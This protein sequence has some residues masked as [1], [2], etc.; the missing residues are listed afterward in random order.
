MLPQDDSHLRSMV[1]ARLGLI[2]VYTTNVP[3]PG[4]LERSLA[5]NTEAVAM[6]RRLGDRSALGYALNARTARVVGH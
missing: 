3:A 4:V 5:L 6:A 1:T 2:P